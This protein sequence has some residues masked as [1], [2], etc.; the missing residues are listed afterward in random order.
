MIRAFYF[1]IMKNVLLLIF[2]A[3]ALFLAIYY[4]FQ[5]DNTQQQ[6]QLANQRILD[7]DTE[8]Y[9]LQKNQGTFRK[10]NVTAKK[11]VT[12]K[13]QVIASPSSLGQLSDAEVN[14]L[15]KR[16][17]TNPEAELKDDLLTNQ[18][19]VLP[20]NATMGGTMAIRD[21]R[22]LN[23]RYALAYFEDGHN[24]GQMVLRYEVKP[25]GQ[26]TWTVL[27]HYLI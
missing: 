21:I 20:R 15:K 6:L 26:V 14:Q 11:K 12:I 23:A 24:G 4:Y 8:I 3:F 2:G 25:G 27:D 17:L 13:P 10:D 22:I 18:K 9:K 19:Q 1:I 7:R 16:G 5:F